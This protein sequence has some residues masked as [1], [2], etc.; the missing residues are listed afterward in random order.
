MTKLLLSDLDGSLPA[1]L[2]G[3]TWQT[4]RVKDTTYGGFKDALVVNPLAYEKYEAAQEIIS[5]REWASG[6]FVDLGHLR[7]NGFKRFSIGQ[8]MHGWKVTRN[9][10]RAQDPGSPNF[11][12]ADEAVEWFKT[13][14]MGDVSFLYMSDQLVDMASKVAP[15]AV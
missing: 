5:K 6:R 11:A 13:Y 7:G 14:R 10:A 12:T 15:A 4:L 2:R 1:H 3:I 8:N 9:D